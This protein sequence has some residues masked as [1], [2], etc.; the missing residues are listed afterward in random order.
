MTEKLGQGLCFPADE[1]KTFIDKLYLDK[2]VYQAIIVDIFKMDVEN[3]KYESRHELRTALKAK[4]NALEIPNYFLYDSDVAFATY[5]IM[6]GIN[7]LQF[8][9]TVLI[10]TNFFGKIHVNEFYQNSNQ[11]IY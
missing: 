1:I 8:D 6:T 3:T 9:E 7:N 5:L 10:A 4:L 2:N 11:K